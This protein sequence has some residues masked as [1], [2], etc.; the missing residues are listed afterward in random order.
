[1]INIS[2]YNL[3]VNVQ[4]FCGLIMLLEAVLF[5]FMATMMQLPIWKQL[6]GLL[7]LGGAIVTFFLAYPILNSYY[8]Y[9]PGFISRPI[10]PLSL[11]RALIAV[12][13]YKATFIFM[14]FFFLFIGLLLIIPIRGRYVKRASKDTKPGQLETKEN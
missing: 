5:F 14:S 4:C 7:P 12:L 1:M 6:F 11:S 8:Y 3:G 13:T 2:L 9:H 10:G